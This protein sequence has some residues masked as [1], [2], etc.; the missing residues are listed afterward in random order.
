[1]ENKK[2]FKILYVGEGKKKMEYN[3][4]YL[5][6]QKLNFIRPFDKEYME[7]NEKNLEEIKEL[8]PAYLWKK[9]I[10]TINPEHGDQIVDV[11]DYNLETE[12]IKIGDIKLIRPTQKCDVLITEYN[13]VLSVFPADCQSAAIY[14]YKK[15]I[16]ALVHSGWRGCL[17]EIIPKTILEFLLRGSKIE[18]IRVILGPMLLKEHFEIKGDH[19]NDFREYIK[20]LKSEKKIIS[21][22]IAK[23][24]YNINLL[25]IILHQL[26]NIGIRKQNINLSLV[27]DTYSAVDKYQNLKYR[28]Y[29]R[30]K[31]DFRNICLF[32]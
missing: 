3:P 6:S 24:C 20:G 14:D 8:I 17:K 27:E 11:D 22:N 30:D 2:D 1:M 28:S 18:N 21:Y 7:I 25:E 19:I 16:K 13:F 31:D 32:I 4:I 5:Y 26:K 15:K 10:Y 12:S 23:D 29:R 9:T